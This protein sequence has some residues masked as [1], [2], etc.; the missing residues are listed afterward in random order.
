MKVIIVTGEP[1]PNGMAATNRVKCFARAIKAGGIDCEVVIFQRT[2]LPNEIHNP[3]ACGIYNGIPYHYVGS[4]NKRHRIRYFRPFFD[5]IDKWRMSGYLRHNL[6]NGDV[7]FLYMGGR[8]ELMLRYMKVA[9]K[10]GAYC[11]RDLCELPYGT[12]AETEKTIKLRKKTIEKQ[13]PQIDGIIS[14]SDAL[15]NLARSYT[16]PSCKYIKVPIMVEYEHYGINEKKMDKDIPFIFHAGTLFQQKDGILGMVEAFGIAKQRI[17]IPIKYILTGNINASSHPEEL[18]YLIE[19]YRLDDSIEFVGYLNRDQIKEYLTSASL[20]ISNRPKSKQD[21][22]GFS[23]KLG[24]YLASGTPLLM[25][26]W[27]EAVNWLENGKS[28]YIVEPEDTTAL[29]DTIVHV[30][31]HPEES[32]KVG[33][34]GQEVCRKCF[35]YRN[36][37]RPLVDFFNQ[38]GE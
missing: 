26:R 2:E 31:T 29:A 19:K 17:D 20:V 22:Y 10:K 13:F 3:L 11:V 14:I 16:L 37:S 24:E 15:L 12:G 21:Y 1:F 4:T 34:A 5:Y 18:R 33:L 38:L 36:W 35:D 27:G 30:F 8:V 23:T 32:R 25:T 7:L 6:S 9:R 28:A